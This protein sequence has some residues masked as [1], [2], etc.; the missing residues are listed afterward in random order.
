MNLG[1]RFVVFT[2]L[3]LLA[4]GGAEAQLT[5]LSKFRDYYEVAEFYSKLPSLYSSY[6]KCLARGFDETLCHSTFT[7]CALNNLP[8]GGVAGAFISDFELNQVFSV[9][10]GDGVCFQCCFVPGNGCHS[11]FIGFPVINCDEDYG[12]GTRPAG[13]TLI[14]DPNAMPGQACLFTPQTCDHLGLC[15]SVRSPQDISAIN[16]NPQ[17]IIHSP[18]A[19]TWRARTFGDN[20]LLD[21]SSFLLNYHTSSPSQ[22]DSIRQQ[23]YPP[24]AIGNFI[25]RRG[26]PGWLH[27]LPASFPTDWSE[28]QFRLDDSTGAYADE[29]SHFNGVRQLGLVRVLASVPNLYNRLAFVESKIWTPDAINQYLAGVQNPDQELLQY[30]SPVVLEVL[31]KN[32]Q[33]QDYRLLA[34]PLAG[35]HA[36]SNLYN[37]CTLADP[38][39]LQ[40]GYQK[41]ASLGIDVQVNSSD[42]APGNSVADIGLLVAWGDGGVSRLTIPAG[43]HLTTAS[44]DYAAGGKYQVIVMVQNEAGL[45]T[46]GALVAETMG[47]GTNPA[48]APTPAISEIQVVD[49]K[50][51]IDS[52]AGDSFLMM[53][54]IEGWPTTAQ[55]Y[56]LGISRALTVP[57]TTPTSFGTVAGWNM[58]AL[59]LPAVTIRPS[60][61]KYG[62]LVG[63][64]GVFFT[65]DRLRLGF[66]STED[67]QLRYQDVPVTAQMIRL[68]P[69]GSNIPVLLT[70]PT[71]GPDGRLKIPIQVNGTIYSHVDLVLPTDVFTHAVQG[72]V[73]NPSWTGITG[74]L[75]ERKP[76]SQPVNTLLSDNFELGHLGLWSGVAGAQ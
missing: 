59:P 62:N 6:N 33:L 32:F 50:A 57:L 68:Y 70:Q 35:E 15:Q 14:T 30:M 12:Q 25:T 69:K 64:Q 38:P 49:L 76:D 44:H 45:R 1:K 40:L 72:P 52:F 17:N 28:E 8:I 66:Y 19:V 23:V 27:A 22:S 7:Y 36:A 65:L 75:A 3:L 5:A 61:F 18:D 13:L 74:T 73:V 34:V 63:F 2:I 51:E 24:T 4:V 21:W 26:C 37:G 31:K 20:T 43:S 56:S 16:N 58:Q 53:F 67:N 48:N 10:C 60:R 41:R 11:S 46:V 42:A 47:T 29:A 9:D 39:S 55:G 54:E 71:F